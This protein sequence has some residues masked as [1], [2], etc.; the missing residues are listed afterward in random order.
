MLNQKDY[1]LAKSDGVK[2]CVKWLE[3]GMKERKAVGD[4][5]GDLLEIKISLDKYRKKLR[6]QANE[7][8]WNLK[9]APEEDNLISSDQMKEF[10]TL[11]KEGKS[12]SVVDKMEYLLFKAGHPDA[13]DN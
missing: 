6:Y 8:E 7:A 13:Y 3:K 4:G 5:V 1:L 10:I 11:L 12:E 2:D 9:P